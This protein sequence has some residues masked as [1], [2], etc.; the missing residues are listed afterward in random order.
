V[1]YTV[2]NLV[3]ALPYLG[4][5]R[6]AARLGTVRT[7]VVARGLSVVVLSLMVI[8]PDFVVAGALLSLRTMLNSVSVPARQSY[9]MGAASEQR[10][11]TVAALSSLPST[12]TAS[13]SPV[14]GGALMAVLIDVPIIGAAVFM[15][16]N[17][18]TYYLAFRHAPLPGEAGT[19]SR[20]L[21]VPASKGVP[22]ATTKP[23]DGAEP[24]GRQLKR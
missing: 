1:L 13:I 6:L 14:V 4:A 18:V 3:S 17:T 19:R 23:A 8:A 24:R 5:H 9:A 11:G 12:V 20:G 16:A 2:V 22:S 10:R 15:G 21:E 7:V